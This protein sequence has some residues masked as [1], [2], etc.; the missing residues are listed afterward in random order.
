MKFRSRGFSEQT[1]KKGKRCPSAMPKCTPVSRTAPFTFPSLPRSRFTVCELTLPSA[2]QRAVQRG[3]A[4]QARAMRGGA[5]PAAPACAL[6]GFSPR[7]LA[8]L[9]VGSPEFHSTQCCWGA[10]PQP[11]LYG[12]VKHQG[13]RVL[14]AG[15]LSPRGSVQRVS[16]AVGAVN[17]NN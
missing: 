16:S 6:G 8:W 4:G 14:W 3:A 2:V 15:C 10:N 11:A 9:S 7:F 12:A 1:Q 17:N 13:Q 5:G